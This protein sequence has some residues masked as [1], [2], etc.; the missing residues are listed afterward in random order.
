[1]QILKTFFC[2]VIFLQSTAVL[3]QMRYRSFGDLIQLDSQAIELKSRSF[4]KN[5]SYD[6][7][8]AELIATQ[9]SSFKM[10][11]YQLRYTSSYYLNLETSFLVNYRMVE[12]TTSSGVALNS[13]LE[14]VILENR[15]LVF[16]TKKFNH[17]F[18]N[19]IQKSI[20]TN[21]IYILP[22]IPTSEDIALGD[23]GFG[24]SFD[25]SL[26]Y[27][28]KYFNYDFKIGYNVPTTDLSSEIFYQFELHYKMK[29][30]S[31][32]AGLGG[33]Q[34]L[35]KDA[36]TANPNQKPVI[37]TGDSRLF[38]SVNRENRFLYAGL[39]LVWGNFLF[40]FIGESIFSG[41]STD[42][43]QALSFNLRWED[44][45]PLS[46]EKKEQLLSQ[47]Y[48]DYLLDG[49][50]EKISKSKKLLR[51]NVGKNKKVVNGMTVDIFSINNVSKKAVIANGVVIESTQ[52]HC[53][54]RLNT[55]SLGSGIEIGD[56][57]RFR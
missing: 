27:F 32:L 6:D 28:D 53:F 37:A 45:I 25:Y 17:V 12:S 3:A 11:D 19:R 1:M 50:V 4:V 40:G 10:T 24:Y 2:L 57:V 7:K 18:T 22:E 38:N 33:V 31:L 55:E 13:G 56:L 47:Q 43:G 29:Y 14:S 5:T 20:F 44:N 48:V 51:V 15:F 34:S 21:K 42:T 23:E 49:F 46:E 9:P 36:F 52:D 39:N 41:R 8:G 16:N 30:G 54:I 35:N 26:T